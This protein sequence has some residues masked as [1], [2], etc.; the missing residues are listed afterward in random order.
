MTVRRPSLAATVAGIWALFVTAGLFVFV[1]VTGIG[2]GAV[3]LAPPAAAGVL[4]LTAGS[5]RVGLA[6]AAV[7]LAFTGTMLL[8][9]GEGLLYVPSLVLVLVAMANGRRSD[10]PRAAR[11][12]RN[13][14]VP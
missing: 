14:G 2:F 7:L 9:G 3:L 4:A 11:T 6:V 10:S 1:L 12:E 5:S 13:E 8:I